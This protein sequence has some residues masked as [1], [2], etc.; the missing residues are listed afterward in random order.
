MLN[1]LYSPKWFYGKDII[2]DIV[3]IIVLVLIGYFSFQYHQ[4]DK[5]RKGH[6]LFTVSFF[7]LAVSF[8]FK[9]LTNFTLYSLATHTQRVG[10]LILTY[11]FVHYS[12]LLFLIGTLVS[13]LFMLLGLYGL[14]SLYYQ[15]QLKSTIFFIIYFILI[16]TYFSD[17]AYY[18]FHLT[19]LLFLFFIVGKYYLNYKK[20]HD[21][22]ARL[23]ACSF[24][25]IALSQIVFMFVGLYSLLYVLAESIQLIGYILLLIS[26]VLVLRYGT[27]KN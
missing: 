27:K 4:F 18:L 20:T 14:Y 25:T 17:S 23:L 11:N 13:R 24:C 6:W 16:N 8:I 22:P 1:I 10:F 12:D 3:S 26:F 2:F 21:K 19:A 7:L 9:I 5:K 15:K